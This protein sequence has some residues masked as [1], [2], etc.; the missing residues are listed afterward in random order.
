MR[1]LI[2]GSA[3]FVGRHF[4][5]A[6]LHADWD[7]DRC[8]PEHRGPGSHDCRE[9][10][11][12]VWSD[13][14]PYTPDLVIHC[15]ALVDGRETIEHKPA[16]LAAHN[17][18]LDAALWEWALRAKPG[19]IVYLSSSAAY[20]VRYQDD[21]HASLNT[22][23]GE[24][25]IDLADPDA[26]D[27]TYGWVKLTGERVA[28]EIR[29]AGVP[30]TVVRPFSGY[31][32][33]QDDCYPFPAI[34]ARAARRDYPLEVWGDGSQTRDFIHI[35]DIVAATLALVD[36]GV[37]GP[38]NLGT[39]IATSMDELARM[40]T[41]TVGYDAPLLHLTTKPQGVK[42]RVASVARLS[43]YYTPQVSLQ[44]GIDRAL[45]H[46]TQRESSPAHG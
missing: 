45:A 46:V 29:K 5:R 16:L 12:S 25:L 20:P 24:E 38:V 42:H 17:L 36:A 19:R 1:A 14:G 2:T 37:D 30:V 28:S 39:G 22:K 21:L 41:D 11:Q 35:D 8:D 15:A 26:P 31:G 33:D 27:Q 7:V 4:V 9:L 3:G 10:F 13:G 44:E 32:E 43:A 40:A 18:Q 6:L 23:L 34:I